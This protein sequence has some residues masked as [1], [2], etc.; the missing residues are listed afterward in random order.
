MWT[1]FA[2]FGG[3]GLSHLSTL[4]YP[5]SHVE[6]IALGD[7]GN[8]WHNVSTQSSWGGWATLGGVSGMFAT[9]AS[10]I[11]A[12]DGHAE[13]FA[14]DKSGGAWHIETG[15]SVPPVWGQWA[16]IG[17]ATLATRPIPARW[18]DGHVQL[19]ARGT[20]N[21]LYTSSYVSGAYPNFTSLN[22]TQVIAGEPSLLVYADYGP[23]IF[24][25]DTSGDVIH[26]WNNLMN[27]GQSP[28]WS[29]WAND[30]GQVIASD[31]M[32]WLR[33][34]GLAEVFGVDGSGNVVK[35]LHDGATW[36]TFATIGTGISPC[37]GGTTLVDAGVPII[38]D[39]GMASNAPD[40][41]MADSG[42]VVMPGGSVDAGTELDGGPSTKPT[43]V[44]AS[45]ADAGE[46]ATAPS[47]GC[48]CRAAGGTESS[49]QGMGLT[50]MALGV[51]IV[52][53]TRKRAS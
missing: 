1:A 49:G 22:P 25:R 26:M 43:T 50:M 11:L 28:S 40:A 33:P 15:T 38:N 30:F 17:G 39:A 3:V 20:D 31:P 46:G 8:V 29:T 21:T 47:N 18:S 42:F 32:A 53:R 7:D 27:A 6:V 9:G 52:V 14:I 4:A 12:S 35:T 41:G 2:G 5:D 16:S 45:H 37:L 19:F 48:S 13:A 44:D 23:E 36:T 10:T 51:V 24:A 34:D